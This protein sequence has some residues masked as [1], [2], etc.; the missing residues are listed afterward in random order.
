MPN[1]NCGD[2]GISCLCRQCD[3]RYPQ[4]LQN[5]S[6]AASSPVLYEL[7]SFSPPPSR[8]Y[9][10]SYGLLRWVQN[11][12]VNRMSQSLT[13]GTRWIIG[14]SKSTI[15][16][17]ESY[18]LSLSFDSGKG[19]TKLTPITSHGVDGTD[20][21]WVQQPARL[22]IGWLAPLARGTVSCRHTSYPQGHGWQ[23][24]LCHGHVGC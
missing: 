6:A 2:W 19:P 12:L 20:A 8:L 10:G 23:L 4:A 21:E 3:A 7:P 14:V 1:S 5:P 18:D 15:T 22:L 9:S 13:L 16:I 24:K 11:K 17:I